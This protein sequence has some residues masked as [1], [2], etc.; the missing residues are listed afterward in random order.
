MQTE[1]IV[2]DPDHLCCCRLHAAENSASSRLNVETS[3]LL[4]S[5]GRQTNLQY[6]FWRELQYH[7]SR[8][9]NLPLYFL[10]MIGSA[11]I[12]FDFCPIVNVS[13]KT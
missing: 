13:Q 5:R 2:L 7:K 12:P 8:V 11:E 6:V 3:Y 10:T 4:G 9:R 1:V